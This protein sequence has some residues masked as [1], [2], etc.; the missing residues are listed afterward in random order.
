MLHVGFD[1]LALIFRVFI[2]Q[3]IGQTPLHVASE[4]GDENLVKFF[5]LCKANPNITD[6]EGL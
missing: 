3:G 6:K 4:L 2:L 1:F 5:Y